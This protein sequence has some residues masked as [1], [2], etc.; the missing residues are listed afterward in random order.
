MKIA[1]LV[2]ILAVSGLCNGQSVTGVNPLTKEDYLQKSKNQKVAY[3]VTGSA[4]ILLMI[5]GGVM[6]LSEFGD[7]LDF[8]GTADYNR[9]K[10]K[11]GD[12]LLYT[13]IG[14][15][16]VSIAFNITSRKNKKRAAALSINSNYRLFQN[17]K[18]I[19]TRRMPALSITIP[20]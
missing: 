18:G 15:G 2:L 1:L 9:K 20:L 3:L 5:V 12:A 4:G 6:S 7:G 8:T 10:Q 14:L 19:T 11:T 13:G 16:A 17:Q